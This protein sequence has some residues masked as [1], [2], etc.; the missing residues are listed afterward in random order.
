M[1]N[2]NPERLVTSHTQRVALSLALSAVMSAPENTWVSG[3]SDLQKVLA[4][5]IKI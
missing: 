5:F 2:V 3:I 1:V 4:S